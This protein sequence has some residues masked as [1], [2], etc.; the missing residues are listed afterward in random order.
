[1][2]LAIHSLNVWRGKP[3]CLLE[4]G[5]HTFDNNTHD[6]I[7]EPNVWHCCNLLA[8]LQLAIG[9]VKIKKS[10]KYVI[11]KYHTNKTHR[12]HRSST[13]RHTITRSQC[14]LLSEPTPASERM[15]KHPEDSRT[16][17]VWSVH[18]VG[19]CGGV[20]RQALVRLERGAHQPRGLI[21]GHP[22]AQVAGVQRRIVHIFFAFCK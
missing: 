19:F 7:L 10:A 6:S 20:L 3:F 17:V 15:L 22:S 4:T 16:K 14:T 1:M 5:M 21:F 18:V 13:R 9:Y 11:R 12:G 2:I 8:S